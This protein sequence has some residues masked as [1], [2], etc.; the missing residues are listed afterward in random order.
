MPRWQRHSEQ[1]SLFRQGP[2]QSPPSKL[3]LGLLVSSLQYPS[4]TNGFVIFCSSTSGWRHTHSVQRLFT[5]HDPQ[6]SP[7][8]KLHPWLFVS[9]SQN[10]LPINNPFEQAWIQNKYC[11]FLHKRKLISK[12]YL[13]FCNQSEIQDKFQ[14]DLFQN[15]ATVDGLRK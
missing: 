13:G 15:E 6:Q 5:I 10:P 7:P 1:N 8:S 2:Q 12:T 4:P 9:S 14:Q 3:Q 11:F